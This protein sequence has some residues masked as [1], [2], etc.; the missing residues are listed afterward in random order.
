[1]AYKRIFQFFVSSTYKDLIEERQ[2]V[3]EAIVSTGNLP[4]GMEHF[5]AGNESQFDYIKKLIDHC[6][7]YIL[8]LAGKY[9]S[10]NNSTKLS[11]TEM[12]FDYAVKNGVPVAVLLVKD[13][14]NLKGAKLESTDKGRKALEKFR[15]KCLDGRMAS[16]WEN[17]DQLVSRTKDAIRN[18]IENSPRPG[19]VRYSDV[20]SEDTGSEELLDLS[21][22]EVL[23]IPVDLF[24]ENSIHRQAVSWKDIVLIVAPV[25]QK[26]STTGQ[27]DEALKVSL[28]NI[29]GADCE[30]IRL[31]LVSYDLAVAL[32]HFDDYSG[33][34]TSMALTDKGYK[35]WASAKNLNK[36]GELFRQ[37]KNTIIEL[38]SC[39]STDV[40]DN[41]LREG[42]DVV[43]SD[44]LDISYNWNHCTS[45]SSFIIHDL[46]LAKLVKEFSVSIHE[47]S[48]H[49]ECYEPLNGNKY[50]FVLQHNE[51][52]HKKLLSLWDTMRYQYQDM[53]TYITQRF[54]IISF[55]RTNADYL[56][57]F[58]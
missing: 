28:G 7:Y 20:N 19:W 32:H 50:K 52:V 14:D 21:M 48:S 12:E 18:L 54:P 5:P 40:I 53:I 6:D 15:K 49:G 17:K 16:F 55:S 11:Y 35:V 10:I 41:F 13:L 44:F 58:K 24:E 30:N 2:A 42:P 39:V 31:K 9:G 22:T 3:M 46:K 25:L 57:V 51:E 33:P 45:A 37:D 56:R 36:D 4:V 27:I 38:F 43:D 8:V 26:N 29:S 23:H 1:M 34:Y 47:M